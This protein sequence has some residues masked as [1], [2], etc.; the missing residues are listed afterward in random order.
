MKLGSPAGVEDRDGRLRGPPL[1]A[2]A[3]VG[4]AVEPSMSSTTGSRCVPEERELALRVR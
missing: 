3:E 2:G 1:G 4:D